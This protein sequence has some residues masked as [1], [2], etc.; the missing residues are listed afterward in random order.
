MK[1]F[2]KDRYG[3]KLRRKRAGKDVIVAD[4]WGLDN[5]APYYEKRL[6]GI[7]RTFVGNPLK[8]LERFAV[9]AVKK[10]TE[11]EIDFLADQGCLYDLE[12][13]QEEWKIE[14]KFM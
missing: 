2:I 5:P 4:L 13:V 9:I 12:T 6:Q 11:D 8:G 10:L 1:T 3:L 14:E 7:K